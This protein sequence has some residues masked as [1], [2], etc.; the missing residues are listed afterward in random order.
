M[1]RNVNR[2]L[3]PG[4][5]QKIQGIVSLC[6]W[7]RRLDGTVSCEIVQRDDGSA[8]VEF[9]LYERVTRGFTDVR[10][11]PIEGE[12]FLALADALFAP[13]ESDAR[14]DAVRKAALD[15]GRY[16][17]CPKCK[18]D[19]WAGC[20]L[21]HGKGIAPV[22]RIDVFLIDRERERPSSQDATDDAQPVHHEPPGLR[23]FSPR[24]RRRYPR[25]HMA[26]GAALGVRRGKGREFTYAPKLEIAVAD[27]HVC[28]FVGLDNR[29][30][31]STHPA[32]VAF[33]ESFDEAMRRDKSRQ[34]RE[35]TA[36]D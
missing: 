36:G 27:G 5:T 3:A 14:I 2:E 25:I 16:G 7:Q 17:T 19:G 12:T 23:W 4:E 6:D 32:V 34:L 9:Q 22:E 31:M 30:V 26:G 33:F 20:R 24:P 10:R 21:C 8:Y 18:G 35:Q 1:S 11:V 29:P 13:V 28:A 15:S